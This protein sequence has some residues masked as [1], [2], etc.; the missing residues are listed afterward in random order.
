MG[1]YSSFWAMSSSERDRGWA[2]DV[3]VGDD[4]T[5]KHTGGDDSEISPGDGTQ[6]QKIWCRCFAP[7]IP[8]GVDDRKVTDVGCYGLTLH[9][10][11]DCRRISWFWQS[12]LSLGQTARRQ[13]GHRSLAQVCPLLPQYLASSALPTSG[14]VA[15]LGS[16][17]RSTTNQWHILTLMNGPALTP[18]A[19]STLHRAFSNFFQYVLK[20]DIRWTCYL[21]LL[22]W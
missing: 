11:F 5:D 20:K 14:S 4:T 8:P 6:C 15:L 17:T 16:R 22:I 10:P 2:I 13:F 9:G 18:S 1:S 21:R 7:D 3:A 19:L 12:W